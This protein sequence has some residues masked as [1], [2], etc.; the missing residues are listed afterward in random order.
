M[1]KLKNMTL[2]ELVMECKAKNIPYGG[3][4]AET[5]RK[6]LSSKKSAPV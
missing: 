2:T 4:D 1:N 5:L 3:E 6:K